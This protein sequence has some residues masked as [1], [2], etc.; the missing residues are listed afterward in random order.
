MD[1]GARLID[2]AGMASRIALLVPGLA[3]ALGSS[4]LLSRSARADI[5]PPEL[6]ACGGKAK[7]DACQGPGGA[8]TCQ[9]GTCSRLDYSKGTPPSSVDYD[10]VK[11]MAGAP[12]PAPKPTPAATPTPAPSAPPPGPKAAGCAISADGGWLGLGLGLLVLGARRTRRGRDRL[13]PGG[14]GP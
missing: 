12:A 7:G 9:A 4:L 11:C 3:L 14:R 13:A 1:S 8:G 6:E 10:C 2:A 5:P